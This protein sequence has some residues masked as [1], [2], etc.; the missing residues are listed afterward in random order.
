MAVAAPIGDPRSR[1]Q[2]ARDQLHKVKKNKEKRNI[3]QRSQLVGVAALFDSKTADSFKYLTGKEIVEITDNYNSWWYGGDYGGDPSKGFVLTL[4]SNI[5][6]TLFAAKKLSS[7][8]IIASIAT[9]QVGTLL[10][11]YRWYSLMKPTEVYPYQMDAFYQGFL[12]TIKG[13]AVGLFAGMGIAY[14]SPPVLIISAF[15]LGI[16]GRNLWYHDRVMISKS[17]YRWDGSD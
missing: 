10:L 16:L 3:E 1:L 13:I 12:A 11:S 5:T 2:R 4:L 9:F 17:M 14:N 6:I 8:P 15:A 7:V